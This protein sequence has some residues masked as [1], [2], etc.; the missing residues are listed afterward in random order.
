M[1]C[2]VL[3]HIVC[4]I[5]RVTAY[6]IACVGRRWRRRLRRWVG[7]ARACCVLLHILLHGLLH[8][9]L[10]HYG[11]TV[12]EAIAA[13]DD[14]MVKKVFADSGDEVCLCVCVRERERERCREGGREGGRAT[15]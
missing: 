11:Q 15:R 8:I 14:M 9:L 7:P 4:L 10:H 12:E 2:C 5:A 1:A 3:L 13:V 6:P